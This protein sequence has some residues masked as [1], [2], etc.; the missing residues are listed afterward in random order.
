MKLKI[1]KAKIE[2]LLGDIAGSGKVISQILTYSKPIL[3][4][5]PVALVVNNGVIPQEDE[6]TTSYDYLRYRFIIRVY[7]SPV[8]QVSATAEDQISDIIESIFGLFQ[9]SDYV[10]TLDNTCD[11]FRIERATPF[12]EVDPSPSRGVDFEVYAETSENH[13]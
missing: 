2:E 8:D 13:T 11:K 10:D 6:F 1:I 9:K 3:E 7:V 5:Y 4:Q 12:S